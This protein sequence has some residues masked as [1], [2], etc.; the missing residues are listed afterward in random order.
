M[1]VDDDYLVAVN[2]E[3]IGIV[4]LS[5]TIISG[6]LWWSSH[7]LQRS[8]YT[9]PNIAELGRSSW[10]L[11][12]SIASKY[13]ENP[14]RKQRDD[15]SKFLKL[16]ADLF[17]CS[18]CSRHMILYM[19]RHPPLLNSK[20]QFQQWLCYFHNAVNKKLKKRM[21]DCS[22]RSLSDRWNTSSACSVASSP[23][24]RYCHSVTA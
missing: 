14:N 2:H 21:F 11:L 4:L 17:P 19:Q 20:N 22:L 10:T 16:F 3:Y 13:P 7:L 1:L 5:M 18:Y 6:L 15:I 24:K 23:G 8:Q 9:S 12:H